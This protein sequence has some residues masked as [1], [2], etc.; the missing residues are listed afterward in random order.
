MKHIKVYESFQ[1]KKVE[2]PKRDKI[3][4]LVEYAGGDA[5]TEHPE[6]HEFKGIKFSEYEQ[7]LDEIQILIDDY[8]LLKNILRQN[9]VNY[10]EISKKYGKDMAQM[11]DNAPNDP[12]SDYQYKCYIDSMKLVGY[13]EEGNKHEAWI[14]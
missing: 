6:L 4:L 14:K 8:K 13:D 5:D 12:Q 2:A 7:H 11:Y 1:F 3:Y 9:R 10:D